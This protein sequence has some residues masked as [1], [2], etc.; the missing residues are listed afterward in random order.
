LLFLALVLYPWM[1]LHIVEKMIIISHLL[2][3]GIMK[4]KDLQGMMINGE[5]MVTEEVLTLIFYD[6]HRNDCTPRNQPD[7]TRDMLLPRAAA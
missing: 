4:I 7:G 5:A 6:H 1:L 3:R 2:L